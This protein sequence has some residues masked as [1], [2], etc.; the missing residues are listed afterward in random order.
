V[1]LSNRCHVRVNKRR[2]ATESKSD[3]TMQQGAILPRDHR[4]I[5]KKNPV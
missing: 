5:A 2:P 3:S 4:W 1:G